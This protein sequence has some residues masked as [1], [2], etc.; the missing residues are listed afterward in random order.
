MNLITSGKQ[1]LLKFSHCSNTIFY[2]LVVISL[3]LDQP[4]LTHT[5]FLLCYGLNFLF[6]FQKRS[7]LSCR[8][9][10]ND[11]KHNAECPFP[12]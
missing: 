1:V 2:S 9:L 6:F 3:T 8:I 5:A 11:L 12:A 10:L 7:Q 4:H